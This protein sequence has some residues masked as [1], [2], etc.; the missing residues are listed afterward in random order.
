MTDI[1]IMRDMPIRELKADTRIYSRNRDVIE[2]IKIKAKPSNI[3][4]IIKSI[5]LDSNTFQINTMTPK[6]DYSILIPATKE[7]AL[8]PTMNKIR[9]VLDKSSERLN[10]QHNANI[11]IYV[12]IDLAS[13]EDFLKIKNQFS[14]QYNLI[15]NNSESVKNLYK[16]LSKE[17][18]FE[19]T[20]GKGRNVYGLMGLIR[21]LTQ[22]SSI[23]L[24]D[25]DIKTYS[26]NFLDNLVKPSISKNHNFDFVKADYVRVQKEGKHKYLYGRVKRLLVSPLVDTFEQ[27]S[28]LRNKKDANQ[29]AS[30]LKSVKY[31]L[32][33]EF[34]FSPKII[35]NIELPL[36]WSLEMEILDWVYENKDSLDIKMTQP[37]LGIYNHKHTELGKTNFDG[38]K[39]MGYQI[40]KNM[41]S[42][43]SK[44]MDIKFSELLYFFDENIEKKL[45]FEYPSLASSLNCHY[46]KEVYDR[47]LKIA[48]NFKESI[49]EG[50]CD[51]QKHEKKKLL[52]WNDERVE[53]YSSFF[54]DIKKE[55]EDYN[56]YKSNIVIPVNAA[57][58]YAFIS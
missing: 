4:N 25:S 51:F 41:L 3:E 31:P 24:H 9:K 32:S 29:Y 43:F 48:K 46:N 54:E 53:K 19:M 30:F 12:G 57:L 16:E 15:N 8:N 40:S 39:K 22:D 37:F 33:G 14:S 55:H 38:L 17:H 47:E 2:S 7:D 50:F 58:K 49:I 27:L 42:N 21:Y 6:K 34:S 28:K 45:K 20:P 18:S 36:D 44:H 1:K 26:E 35:Q 13:D 11:G 56:K 5:E 23:T 52:A 10:Y